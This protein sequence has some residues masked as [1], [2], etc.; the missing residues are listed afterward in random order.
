[1]AA[2]AGPLVST[3]STRSS[4]SSRSAT[5]CRTSTTSG[6]LAAPSFISTYSVV[7]SLALPPQQSIRDRLGYAP[8]LYKLVNKIM[9]VE[10]GWG[11]VQTWRLTTRLHTPARDRAP[12]VLEGKRTL[13]TVLILFLLIRQLIFPP[14]HYIL[15]SFQFLSSKAC[16]F[17][18]TSVVGSLGGMSSDTKCPICSPTFNW[19]AGGTLSPN[20]LS[21]N[22][23]VTRLGVIVIVS[24]DRSLYM[25]RQDVVAGCIIQLGQGTLMPKLC[26]MHT[27]L[28]Q[29][30][31][32]ITSYWA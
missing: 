18:L 11:R 8:I 6:T 9:W 4:S 5:S 22:L 24:E 3:F 14:Y 16:Q 30:I 21:Q 13:C 7:S 1:M 17:S 29:F 28:C 31:K 19:Q 20:L 10:G 12:S 27:A 2:T 32:A 25:R 15:L 23:L 26:Q